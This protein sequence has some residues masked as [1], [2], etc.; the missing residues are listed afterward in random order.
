MSCECKHVLITALIES[1]QGVVDICGF[2][3]TEGDGTT[4]ILPYSWREK[5]VEN[6]SDGG[7]TRY[8]SDIGATFGIHEV[9]T[10]G[11]YAC[12]A[13]TNSTEAGGLGDDTYTYEGGTI[14]LQS[15]I[16]AAQAAMVPDGFGETEASGITQYEGE[17]WGI[18]PSWHLLRGGTAD[19]SIQF[20]ASVGSGVT[21]TISA[22]K[23]IVRFRRIHS[24]VPVRINCTIQHYDDVS[25]SV[26]SPGDPETETLI[27][28]GGDEYSETIEIAVDRVTYPDALTVVMTITIDVPTFPTTP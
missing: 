18:Q 25:A 24:K 4:P 14:T 19:P 2:D 8:I 5:R 22:N 13:P 16:E 7:G 15:A 10:G 3:E 26:P 17:D 27:I 28:P 21:N 20:A 11:S 12:G 23:Q 1:Y 6:S 9:T